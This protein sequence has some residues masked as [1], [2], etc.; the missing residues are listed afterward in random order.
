[1]HITDF[2]ILSLASWRISSLLVNEDGPYQLFSRLRHLAGVYHDEWNEAKSNYE[3]GKLFT[4]LWCFSF[5][6]GIVLMIIYIFYPEQTILGC[7]PFAL[8]AGAILINKHI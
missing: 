2:I 4:C 3:I 5:Y 8:S 6:V 7:L 1:M